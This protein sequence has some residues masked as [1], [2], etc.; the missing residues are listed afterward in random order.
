MDLQELRSRIDE[1]DDEL[2]RLFARRM[3]V[4]AE[5]ARYKQR[6]GIAIFD[7]ERETQ[8]LRALSRKVK[9]G[10]EAHIS[11]LFSLLFE[12]SRAEQASVIGSE[13]AP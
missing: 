8:K 6:N 5:I 4:S 1:I 2:V 7:P 13:E 12:L 9:K 10:H 3:E 11:A